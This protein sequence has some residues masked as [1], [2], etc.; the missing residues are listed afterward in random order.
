MFLTISTHK[1]SSIADRDDGSIF[2]GLV[3]EDDKD[4][5]KRV[6]RNKSEKKR[7]DQFNI[8]IKELGSMLPG[9]ARKM[10]KSTV[11]QK[12]IDFLRKHKEITAQSDASEIR[13]DWKPTFLSNEEFTQLM[14]EALDGFFLAIMTDGSIIYVSESVTPLLEHLPSDLV[15]QSIFNFVPEGE[16]SEVYKILSTHLLESDSLTPEYL[17]SKNQLEF[18]CH[19]LRGTIDPK[20]PP[21]YEYVKCIGNFKSLSNMPNSAHNGYEETIQRP[22]RPSYEDR[23]CFVATVRLATPQF[24]KEMSTVEEPNEEFTSRHSLEWKF[25]FLDHRA[26]PIIGYLPFE[27]LGTSG[28]DYYHVDDLENLAKCH[29]HLMQYGKGK[30]CYYRFL[31]KGQQWIWLQTHYYITYHQWN[32][33]PEF[34]VC[35]HTVVSYA[36]VRAERRR[37]LGIEESL[38]EIIA[39]KSQDSSSD[40]HIN[41]VSLKEALE[42]FDRSPTPSASSRS[43]RKSSH[44]AVSDPSSTPTKMTVD[45]STPPRQN[46][47]AHE[48]SAQRRSSLGSQPLNSQSVGQPLAQPMMTQPATLQLQQSMSQP[49]LQ[50]SA[51]LGAMQHLKDQLEQ[52]TR[53]IEANIHRQQEELRKIQEQLQMVH[54][55]GLQMFLQQSPPGLNFGSVQLASGN[56]STIQQITPISMQGQVVQ[57]NQIQGGMNS[58]HVGSQHMMQQQSLQSTTAQHNQQNILSGHSQQ[59]SLSTQGQNTLSAPLYNTMVISQPAPG[60]VVQLP[61][62]LQQTN[63]QNAA[64]TTFAQDRQ[65]RFSQGQQLVTK[66]VTAPVACGT[67]M[68]P[69]TMFM[70]QVVTAYPTFAAQQQ[71]QQ[72]LQTLSIPPQQQQQEQHQEQPQQQLASVQPPAQAQLTQHPQQFLQT[73]RLLHGNQSTQLILSAAFPLQ[74]STFAQ[75][76]HQ[77]SQPQPPQMP[78][79]RADSMT[80]ASKVPPQ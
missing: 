80:E 61:S 76:H 21:T 10:D 3:E 39:E 54:G 79:H 38:P 66:L 69:S 56:A 37:E 16:H 63:N 44:T 24:I 72:Q 32:S 59:A 33:R 31:T 73:S 40:N 46:L 25:L 26:P 77:Q 62:N 1:M 27:V 23:I 47:S 52:R 14:L 64:I 35:T 12:S 34:I 18:C 50:F 13:Q 20:E 8:L 78:R 51:Q 36:E 71:Q 42:R 45:T 28:Y 53:M 30:S 55:Q 4:K 48:K 57:T 60:N 11:L 6:S 70:G 43:S 74:Q 15:D 7:R 17:K 29:E 41:T 58:G 49:M 22:H 65:I 75:S 19:M 68:V 5:A 2:D 67:V 9:N